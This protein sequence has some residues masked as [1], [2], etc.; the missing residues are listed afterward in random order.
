[1][2]CPTERYRH[3]DVSGDGHQRENEFSRPQGG[4][5]VSGALGEQRAR[6]LLALWSSSAR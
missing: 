5:G 1:M 2:E 3:Q 6:R 4:S